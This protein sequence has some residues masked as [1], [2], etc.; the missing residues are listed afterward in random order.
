MGKTFSKLMIPA[1]S[2]LYQKISPDSATA[3]FFGETV[4]SFQVNNSNFFAQ[5]N[6][7]DME[8]EG[9]TNIAGGIS[10]ALDIALR[11]KDILEKE[12]NNKLFDRVTIEVDKEI[13]ELNK[14]KR[15]NEKREK[16]E[17]VEQTEQ[18]LLEE[19]AKRQDKINKKMEKYKR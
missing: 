14:E 7:K 2:M 10:K 18:Q 19:R 3:V 4:T 12:H 13:E 6:I 9:D 16:G 8:L 11:D 17:K 1:C 5:D 15:K